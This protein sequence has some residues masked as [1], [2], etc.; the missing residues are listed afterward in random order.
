M[1]FNHLDSGYFKAKTKAQEKQ[2]EKMYADAYRAYLR[3]D[4]E[5]VIRLSNEQSKK[6]QDS[7]I[8]PQFQFLQAMSEGKKMDLPTLKTSLESFVK[9]FP[10]SEPTPLAKSILKYI[11][12]NDSSQ[13]AYLM[14]AHLTRTIP[15]YDGDTTANAQTEPEEER[16]L[17]TLDSNPPFYYVLAVK[18]E[19][20]DINQVKFNAIN[21]NLDYFTNFD[22]DIQVKELTSKSALLVISPFESQGQAMNYFDLINYN[23]EIFEG[24]ER[25][26][27]QH[28]IISEQ[29]Y[30]SLLQSRDVEAYMTFFEENLAR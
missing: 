8:T 11:A 15:N 9:Q 20:V 24:I 23:E 18:S 10:K 30:Q 28:F 29:N 14:T 4:Y 13:I 1:D 27:T 17:F 2:V 21:Y 26:F 25:V 22:F 5:T 16:E 7:Y 19:F 3:G 12:Q 6:N